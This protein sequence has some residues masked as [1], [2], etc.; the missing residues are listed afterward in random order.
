MIHRRLFL[1]GLIV[2]MTHGAAVAQSGR[3][4]RAD[5]RVLLSDFGYVGAVATDQRRVYAATANGLE[6]YDYTSR[7]WELPSTLED[8]YPV[9][10]RP[11]ALAHDP[12]QSEL[13]LA[14]TNGLTASIW[15]LRLID[16]RWERGPSLQTRAVV[17]IVPA[18]SLADDAFYLRTFDGWM[19][20]GRIGI[21]A[22]PV[23]PGQVPED[24]IAR[25]TSLVDRL[26][27][28]PGFAAWEPQL[29]FDRFRRR[30]AL[31]SAAAEEYTSGLWVGRAGGNLA[32]F[33]TRSFE[34]ENFSF[35][36]VS[37]GTAAI[38]QDA[39]GALWFGSDGRGQRVGLT[40]VPAD[41]STSTILESAFERVP[42]RAVTQI[43]PVADTLWVA[44]LDGLYRCAACADTATARWQRFGE[45]DGLP[46][47]EVS[48]LAATRTALWVATRRGLVRWSGEHGAP[49]FV[50]NRINRL[51]VHG[52]TLLV[53]TDR[54]LWLLPESDTVGDGTMAPAPVPGG[55][56]VD[57][58]NIGPDIVATDG[59]SLYRRINGAWNG[60][61]RTAHDI[62]RIT[63]LYATPTHLWVA[64]E[65]GV[66]TQDRNTGAWQ[67]LS[68]PSDV[69]EG[70]V[71]DLLITD[72]H[73]WLAT[74]AGALRITRRR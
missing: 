61:E 56:I 33:D 52:D 66:A 1:A 29:G 68:V 18:T 9:G 42:S 43:L 35:G 28:D 45:T 70:P 39:S 40:R 17:A 26:E 53:A 14:T 30:W 22:D 32:R 54:G 67:S 62:G 23:A 25:A 48:G 74:P 19:R 47:M 15:R 51:A 65:R 7:R 13:I 58:V 36:L 41:L 60:P 8:G 11:T 59:R 24:V 34:I 73:V 71:N 10:E 2:A 27:R 31:T 44:A 37:R 46:A 50:G 63:R 21:F 12:L 6:I 64:G 72:L 3:F 69:P 5:D 4:W 57:V 55:R 16:G 38:A 20:L 49:R